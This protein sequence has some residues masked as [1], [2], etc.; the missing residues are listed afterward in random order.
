M[1]GLQAARAAAEAGAWEQVLAALDSASEQSYD[2]ALELRASALYAT[3]D[4]EGCLACWERL[5]AR[6]SASG[7][8]EGSARAAAMTAL[9]LLIDTGL[10]APVRSWIG[11]AERALGG[12]APGPVHAL[13]AMVGTYERLLSGD[14]AAAREHAAAATALGQ[15]YDVAPAVVIGGVALARLH[16]LDGD[17]DAGLRALDEAASQLVAGTVDPLTTGIMLCE[18]VCAA[19]GLAMPDLAREWT[20]LM[21]H[22]GGGAAIGSIHGRC[23][24]HRAELLRYTGPCDAAEAEALAA[25]A[26][27]RPWLRREYGWPLVELGT[28]RLRKDD[29][30]GA[31]DAFLAAESIAWSA[32]PG[33]SLLRLAQG[34]PDGAARL[35]ANAIAD[36]ADTPS[37]E[38]P[39]AG[40]LR[41]APL[42]DAQ[43]E[44][45]AARQDV[46]TC[47]VAADELTRIAARYPSRGLRASAALAQARAALLA[48]RYDA[49]GRHARDAARIWA[50]LDA[51][52][53]AAVARAVVGDTLAASGNPAQA[54]VEWET[55]GRACAAYG[56][57][58]RAEALR[59]R[60]TASSGAIPSSDATFHRVG[61]QRVITF[62]GT[63]VTL[64]D[65]V[66]FRHLER[67]I[68][69]PGEA[70]PAADLV[71]TAR[72][73]RVDQLGLPALDEQARDA[74]R[75]R[76]ADIDDDIAEARACN[77]LARAAAADRERD[78]LLAELR[79]AVGIGGRIRGV[80]GSAERARTSVFRSIRYALDRLSR[81]QP[82][83]AEHLRRSVRTGTACSYQPDPLARIRWHT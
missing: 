80:G 5:H 50:E 55:A 7:D 49:A 54:R 32:Q 67:L 51:P 27:L 14:L 37:K 53:D 45:A 30:A 76:L 78:F 6:R 24:V 69:S 29:L 58:R 40:D 2:D 46:A 79:R 13:L 19:Q 34:D 43:A 17:P 56:A 28:I 1:T 59:S 82:A 74:Y 3:G 11:R 83:L 8:R 20:D 33:L 71:Q 16:V 68:R 10:M 64:P 31:E 25:C 21:E 62:A 22:S 57:A 73:A 15:R 47:T 38:R 18:V 42:L 81:D 60:S 52:Y 41:L 63:S 12:A 36:P 70:I 44:I 39:P 61:Q 65:L 35:I 26:E 23:R 77:D 4:L 9:F 72:C 66:G 75:R 48:T